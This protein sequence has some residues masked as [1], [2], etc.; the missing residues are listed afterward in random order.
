MDIRAPGTVSLRA[1]RNGPRRSTIAMDGMQLS[2]QPVIRCGDE[3]I[4]LC[5]LQRCGRTRWPSM[6]KRG[7]AACAA[8]D[9][10]GDSHVDRVANATPLPSLRI[11]DAAVRPR[12]VN[13]Q[14]HD[15]RK[16]D[17]G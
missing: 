12:P 10:I 8:M 6:S 1:L 9:V 4:G 15:L 11:D 7:G 3:V 2:L 5:E 14:R 17:H 13:M 16:P